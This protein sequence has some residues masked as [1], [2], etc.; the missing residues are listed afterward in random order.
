VYLE[1]NPNG[2]FMWLERQLGLPISAAIAGE[3]AQMAE[4]RS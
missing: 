4:Q 1:V 3:L 2:Q